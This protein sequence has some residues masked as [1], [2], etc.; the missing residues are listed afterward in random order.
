[1]KGYVNSIEKFLCTST[2]E[3]VKKLKN[4]F[5]NAGEG[6]VRSWFVLIN[7]LKQSVA[8]QK[9]NRT[10]IVAIEYD[11]PSEGMG[12]DC[13]VAGFNQ[14][15]QKIAVI[16]ESKQWGDDYIRENKFGTY[17]TD[18]MLLHPQIQVNRHKLSF[19]DYLDT[20]RKYLVSSS[21]FI[22][23]GTSSGILSLV[24]KNPILEARKVPVYN[25]LDELIDKQAS[26]ITY[27]SA[28]IKKDLEIATLC[29]SKGIE[30]AM[31]SLITKEEP[32]VLTE[33]QMIVY[34]Q[35]KKCINS[36]KRV[37][38]VKGD[39]GAG[40]TAIMLNLYVELLNKESNKFLP[41]FVPGAQNTA[42]YRNKYN[43]V[44]FCFTYSYSVSKM[45]AQNKNKICI[46][47]MDEAQHNDPGIITNIINQGAILVICYDD[48]QA[49]K[50]QNSIPELK[51][52]ENKD[53]FVALELRGSVRYNGSLVAEKN[54]RKFLDGNFNFVNDDKFE[55]LTFTDTNAF[56]NKMFE[57]INQNPDAK[58]SILGL[59]CKN[60]NDYTCKGKN[61]SKLFTLWQGEED[62]RPETCYIEY[63]DRKNYLKEN[64]G[65]LRV[66]TWW[67]PGLDV[68]YVGVIIGKDGKISMNGFEAYPEN[69]MNY[70]MMINIAQDLKFP[71]KLL[72]GSNSEKVKNI[73]NYINIQGNIDLKTEFVS[74]FTDYL[75]NMY[76]IM[77]T[78]GKRG[79]YVL[80]SDK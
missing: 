26:C 62:K 37:V 66:G 76:Y 54:I 55:F 79:C 64:N 65:L 75:K 2:D 69:S 48:K 58:V 57:V 53:Y 77:C 41:I 13:I 38:R 5:P 45:I 14:N 10:C 11:L 17:R 43:E 6:Q 28:E 24:R 50:S 44:S 9:L 60:V 18:D 4:D 32:F 19:R 80:F 22:K 35:I 71:E 78:R 47:F 49:I 42:Y 39:A 52:L 70:N 20:C 31:Y 46:V 72:K 33:E 56:Q 51:R 40:K 8:F 74:S 21:V 27:G 16:I 25:T 68:D 7:D 59:L 12:A 34:E 73:I 61:D 36:G 29:P 15:N 1:M 23:N 30:D 67:M 3:I 63:L